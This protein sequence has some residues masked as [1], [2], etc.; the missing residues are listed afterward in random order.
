MPDQIPVPDVAGLAQAAAGA[1][2]TGAGLAVGATTTTGSPTVAAGNVIRTNPVAGTPVNAGSAVDLEVSSGPAQVAVPDVAGLAQ[3][4]AGA[5]LTGAGLA[6]GATTTTGSP[7]VAAG[8]VIRTNPVAGTPVNAG[9]AVDLAVSSGPTQ[10]AVP[11]VAGL[12]QAAAGA[13]LTGAGLAVGATTTTGSPTVAAGNVINTNPRAGVLVNQGSRVDLG[14]STGK[15][16][17]LTQYIPGAMFAIITLIV[18]GIIAWGI[19]G[20][21]GVLV[22]LSN[23]Q[24]ARGLIAFLIA[25]VTVGIA[26]ILVLSTIISD[27]V[28][29]RFDHGKQVL[30]TMI[31]ILG[32]IVGFY[33]ATLESR[34]TQQG[35]EHQINVTNASLPDGIVNKAYKETL[36]ETGG[37]PPLKWSVAPSLPAELSLEGGVLSGTPKAT[38]PKTTYVVTVTDSASPPTPS[39]PGVITLEIKQ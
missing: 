39:T 13:A 36:Q 7:T 21:G 23:A 12:A 9:S 18:L 31:G 3:A 22:N 33:F 24:I 6:V 26:L 10:V 14:I 35:T 11:D 5:A 37:I 32:T 16:F 20:Q 19:S 17:D 8:N 27:D 4:A 34:T 29:N 2:L 15:R 38:S 1:A 28:T 30:T 25:V